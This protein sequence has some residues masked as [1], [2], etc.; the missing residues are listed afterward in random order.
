MTG[1]T[2]PDAQ[3]GRAEP[4]RRATQRELV[5]QSLIRRPDAATGR[6]AS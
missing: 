6:R 1:R 5:V 3:A 2:D 4:V